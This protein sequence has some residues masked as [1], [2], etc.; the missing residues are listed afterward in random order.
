MAKRGEEKWAC[1]GKRLSIASRRTQ[2]GGSTS[3]REGGRRALLLT[4]TGEE[5]SEAKCGVTYKGKTLVLPEPPHFLLTASCREQKASR[6]AY[7]ATSYRGSMSARC[8]RSFLGTLTLSPGSGGL[9][10]KR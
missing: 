7:T 2:D 10:N 9:G 1:R 4:R 6:T 8:R 5:T 3:E